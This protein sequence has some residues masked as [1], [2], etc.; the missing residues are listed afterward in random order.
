VHSY[1]RHFAAGIPGKQT[2]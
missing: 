1:I 2:Y